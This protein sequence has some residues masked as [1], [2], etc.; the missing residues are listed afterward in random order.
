MVGEKTYFVSYNAGLPNKFSFGITTPE[1]AA[2]SAVSTSAST[3][4]T[5]IERC[6]VTEASL[7]GRVHHQQEN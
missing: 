7:T 2:A 3:R 5:A 6:C 1:V 4:S